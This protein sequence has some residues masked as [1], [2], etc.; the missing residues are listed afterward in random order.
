VENANC[1]E[2]LRV[3]DEFLDGGGVA[4]VCLDAG[5]VLGVFCFG[6]DG[7]G[8][9]VREED[10]VLRFL[11]KAFCEEGAYHAGGAGDEDAGHF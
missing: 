3:R 2:R 1:I 4:E 10:F 11:E 7:R 8:D 9:H 5:G 6:G